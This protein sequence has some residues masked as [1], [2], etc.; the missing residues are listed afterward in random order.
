[1]ENPKNNSFIPIKAPPHNSAF[2]SKVAKPLRPTAIRAVNN[3]SS[4]ISTNL[5]CGLVALSIAA[6]SASFLTNKSEIFSDSSYR[7]ASKF[8]ILSFGVSALLL[9]LGLRASDNSEKVR[10]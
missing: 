4:S 1:M 8:S 7:A 10:D 3:N 5:C 2:S 6:I 9:M